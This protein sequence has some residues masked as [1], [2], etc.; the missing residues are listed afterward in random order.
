MKNNP[1]KEF[2]VEDLKAWFSYDEITGKLLW[3]QVPANNLYKVGGEVGSLTSCKKYLRLGFRGKQL[4]L[5][6]VVWAI[7]TGSWPTNQV[8][9]RDG[10]PFNN[11]FSNLREATSQENNRNKKSTKS[12]V[13]PYKGVYWHKF[14]K[15]WAATAKL[16]GKQKHLGSFASETEAAKAYDTFAKEHYGEF[17][18]L[19]FKEEA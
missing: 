2:P 3:K 8:D 9:H 11:C 15:T 16:N 6:R 19:N 10:N 5:H 14:G 4:L 12:S 17:A 13:S 7:K 1:E 18:H